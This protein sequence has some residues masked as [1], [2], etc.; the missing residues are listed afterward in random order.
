MTIVTENRANCRLYCFKD[1]GI[2]RV[3][4]TLLLP[5]TLKIDILR[6]IDASVLNHQRTM[7]RFLCFSLLFLIALPAFAQNE[8][9]SALGQALPRDP[10]FLMRMREQISQRLQQIQQALT[11]VNPN[12]TQL[13]ETLTVQQADLIKQHADVLKEL[14]TVGTGSAVMGSVLPG[15]DGRS[16][17]MPPSIVQPTLPSQTLPPPIARPMP[18]SSGTGFPMNPMNPTMGG[19][20][21]ITPNMGMPGVQM[22]N[23]MRGGIPNWGNP[24]AVWDTGHWGPR[25][26]RELSDVQQSVES[27]QKEI[28]ELK[29]LIRKLETQIQLLNRTVL[30]ERINEQRM[31]DRA[32]DEIER[33]A[34]TAPTL[35]PQ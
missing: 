34:T 32:K 23:D 6:K 16:G 2:D 31:L 12:D 4:L 17:A 27:L 26:P 13:I 19:P 1:C 14:Q 22:P 24:Q 28:A 35:D 29:E 25:L 10:A 20:L 8:P 30:L 7:T 21:P 15:T 33:S 5:S 9:P 18:E 3:P 11:V